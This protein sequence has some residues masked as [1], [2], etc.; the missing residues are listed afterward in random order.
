[1]STN[2]LLQSLSE[3]PQLEKQIGCMTG[4][5]QLF[6]RHQVLTGRRLY[7]HKRIAAAASKPQTPTTSNCGSP[8]S[9]PSGPLNENV[10]RNTSEEPRPKHAPAT[11]QQRSQPVQM[12]TTPTET[13]S[14]LAFA[15]T[16]PLPAN[17]ASATDVYSRDQLPK[18]SF[19]VARSNLL[20]PRRLDSSRSLHEARINVAHESKVY[21]R[22]S[23]DTAERA[24]AAARGA[25]QELSRITTDFNGPSHHDEQVSIHDI[26]RSS[27]GHDQQNPRSSA[28]PLLSSSSTSSFPHRMASEAS[29]CNTRA[30][31]TSMP[32]AGGRVDASRPPRPH[33]KPKVETSPKT[34]A[35]ISESLR[36]LAKLR[37]ASPAYNANLG[38]EEADDTH[39]SRNSA[40]AH[41]VPQQARPSLVEGPAM[42]SRAS[43][44]RAASDRVPGRMSSYEPSRA[45]F[46][47]SLYQGGPKTKDGP[48]L[49]LDS[50]GGIKADREVGSQGKLHSR[51]LLSSRSVSCSNSDCD[52]ESLHEKRT[53]FSSNVVARL[54]GLDELPNGDLQQAH[55]KLGLSNSSD[56]NVR[57]GSNIVMQDT[58]PTFSQCGK[59]VSA[60]FF[61][62]K[63][64]DD[65][66]IPTDSE[67]EEEDSYLH[68]EP[69]SQQEARTL[70]VR[71]GSLK[72]HAGD[73]SAT[74]ENGNHLVQPCYQPKN[75][76]LMEDRPPHV[77]S[78]AA[79]LCAQIEAMQRADS[80]YKQND[81]EVRTIGLQQSS[82]PELE[83]LKQL[84]GSIRPKRDYAKSYVEK[85]PIW[86]SPN[87]P[88]PESGRTQFL[89]EQPQ[90]QA[91]QQL[92]VTWKTKRMLN[93]KFDSQVH[94][95][96]NTSR[97][98]Y[99]RKVHNG[100]EEAYH[101][102]YRQHKLPENYSQSCRVR[103]DAYISPG[104]SDSS[105]YNTPRKA[106]SPGGSHNLQTT[107]VKR[108]V[109]PHTSTNG[110]STRLLTS[111]RTPSSQQQRLSSNGNCSWEAS[112]VSSTS[113]NAARDH[114][115]SGNSSYR[116]ANKQNKQ[117]ERG[118]EKKTGILKDKKE[119]KANL[120][121]LKPSSMTPIDKKV[122][123]RGV[124]TTVRSDP[125]R[126]QKPVQAKN[127][128]N[129]RSN[130]RT[131]TR[132]STR[133]AVDVKRKL[134]FSNRS[135][136][137]RPPS[138]S[139][140]IEDP[141][142]ECVDKTIIGGTKSLQ[143]CNTSV[144]LHEA[145]LDV[146]D[147]DPCMSLENEEG[148][149]ANTPTSIYHVR[150]EGGVK[151]PLLILAGVD[152]EARTPERQ[153]T[154]KI[155][156]RDGGDASSPIR[157]PT[158]A[159]RLPQVLQ[160]QENEDTESQGDK[161]TGS[162]E[163]PSPISVLEGPFY[164]DDV[165]SP[166]TTTKFVLKLEEL[167]E[168][169]KE[170]ASKGSS[171][172]HLSPL[173]IRCGH[174]QNVALTDFSYVKHLL[175]VSCSPQR[176]DGGENAHDATGIWKLRPLD[177]HY[178]LQLEEEVAACKTEP[179]SSN[180]RRML[181]DSVNASMERRMHTWRLCQHQPWLL[182]CECD[183]H[184]KITNGWSAALRQGIVGVDE[185]N[186]VCLSSEG[187]KVLLEEV[188]E[189]IEANSA[190]QRGKVN[191][192]IGT[193]IGEGEE[194]EG[195]ACDEMVH[196]LEED[197]LGGCHSVRPNAWADFLVERGELGLDLERLIF[198]DLIDHT[199]RDL[200]LLLHPPLSLTT[201]RQLF[202]L[203]K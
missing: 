203:H 180:W 8:C 202:K 163:Q 23:V 95:H 1:M 109:H 147:H 153:T 50:R 201:K 66:K 103:A 176:R 175:E 44:P 60:S 129:P 46:A 196:M 140:G 28:H 154:S 92:A 105:T 25:L 36:M 75:H 186:N 7:G 16:P 148:F 182:A 123:P 57:R 5:L 56:Q 178:F 96:K 78:P 81:R 2:K 155:F 104:S 39:G 58:N 34:C 159:L 191:G 136:N 190:K 139:C 150:I 114:Y 181:F 30:S 6:D 26:V 17:E 167:E 131:P 51:T 125:R 127:S 11:E 85:L 101:S 138:E 160:T 61:P 37:E 194:E 107:H 169:T 32:Q 80:L 87:K 120:V 65:I 27:L 22:K 47:D 99:D 88:Q 128:D 118:A 82:N 133:Q 21:A 94:E 63:R 3:D 9:D 156:D 41:C 165:A 70:N 121:S 158:G 35:D 102:S 40:A 189:E 199:I 52:T 100:H 54:M 18:I 79:R 12:P 69:L 77:L 192:S 124:S 115:A 59:Y 84:L 142:A 145:G 48:R 91:E 132:S 45:S 20:L 90:Q 31:I 170:E 143:S 166:P 183:L 162:C 43:L 185:K 119:S 106:I 146:M 111:P 200:G 74:T 68:L 62:S 193:I 93:D 122:K 73:Q 4:I 97:T 98:S 13:K 53:S 161:S 64:R 141:E 151:S 130:M 174:P 42:S 152:A 164:E 24:A 198:K 197:I 67:E 76:H 15:R 173:L 168:E 187:A 112:S 71:V 188:W 72:S 134:N 177:F 49:S 19:D 144:E 110:P 179:G 89:H 137:R 195:V 38:N 117:S 108:M 55:P 116:T 83:A 10:L 149:F 171:L 113:S 126:L 14:S 86:E 29:A 33:C 157:T 172:Q 184:G 135:P